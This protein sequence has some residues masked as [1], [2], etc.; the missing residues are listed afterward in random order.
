MIRSSDDKQIYLRMPWLRGWDQFWIKRTSKSLE[1]PT[2]MYS[3][4]KIIVFGVELLAPYI[5]SER[6]IITNHGVCNKE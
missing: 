2:Y 5:S 3:I 4:K 1:N 6:Q